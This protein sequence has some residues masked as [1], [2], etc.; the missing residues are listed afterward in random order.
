[1]AIHNSTKVNDIVRVGMEKGFLE[2]DEINDFLPR[3]FFSPD[4]VEDVFDFLSETVIDITET[5][6]GKSG[7]GKEKRP[8][9]GV[10]EVGST[11]S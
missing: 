4:D 10:A 9:E 6:Q 2:S 3:E 11:R 1:M 7:A 8:D 5:I